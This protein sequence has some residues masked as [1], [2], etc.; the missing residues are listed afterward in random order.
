MPARN[1]VQALIRREL[2]DKVPY[3]TYQ[4]RYELF[5]TFQKR[6]ILTATRAP[7]TV[8]QAA[9]RL[10]SVAN[11]DFDITGTNAAEAGSL[12]AV[13]GGVTLTTQTADNDQ[14]I[15]SPAAAVNSVE[16]SAWRFVEWEPEH[17]LRFDAIVDLGQLTDTL[18]HVGM[19]KTAVLDL[20]TDADQMKF[21][22]SSEGAVS[23]ANWTC[24]TSVTG[25]S[26]VEVD[27]GVAG[28]AGTSVRLSIT[29][30]AARVPRFYINGAK[31]YTGA[32]LTAGANLIPVM[33]IQ[34]LVITTVKALSLRALRLSRDYLDF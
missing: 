13:D 19:V 31:V 34:E 8:N 21:Q 17:E 1:P 33:G 30:N 20:T 7:G 28:A 4:S 15:V 16:Q 26:D 5:E 24:C 22:F 9:M 11:L 23:T 27:S 14:M 10:L 32:A 29:T 25:S 2:L 3:G 6:P 18:V 12:L